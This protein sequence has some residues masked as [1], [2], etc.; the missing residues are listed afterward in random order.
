MVAWLSSAPTV[1]DPMG[2]NDKADFGSEVLIDSIDGSSRTIDLDSV[3]SGTVILVNHKEYMK[4][5]NGT[6][7]KH[8]GST[9][10]SENLTLQ[11]R[12]AQDE[13]LPVTLIHM[14]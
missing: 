11:I 4:I 6:W 12:E 9:I 10:S 1:G 7:V 2:A 3:F 5:L 8:T 14:G 13:D